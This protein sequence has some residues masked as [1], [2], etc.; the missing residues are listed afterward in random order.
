MTTVIMISNDN[1]VIITNSDDS[2][3]STLSGH[4]Q[5]VVKTP[6]KM[7]SS[8]TGGDKPVNSRKSYQSRKL[9][10]ST[11]DSDSEELNNSG[12]STTSTLSSRSDHLLPN[13]YCYFHG[14]RRTLQLVKTFS[15]Q[16]NSLVGIQGGGR[17]E[18]VECVEI[19]S[20]LGPGVAPPPG[21]V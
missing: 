15:S 13:Y 6:A 21:H 14:F 7:S 3:L 1:S 4:G 12:S 2:N 19:I 17:G 8:T 5:S 9:S 20:F 10:V 11:V 16:I 18:V